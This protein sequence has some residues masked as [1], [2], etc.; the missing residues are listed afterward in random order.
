MGDG[1]LLQALQIQHY[2]SPFATPDDARKEAGVLRYS[3]GDDRDGYSV[4]GMV[5]HQLWTNTTD[6][7]IRA[8]TEGRVPNRFGSLDPS[9]GGRAWRS[10]LS[11]GDQDGRRLSRGTAGD[12]RI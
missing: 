5:Y 2:G 3:A 1:H 7:P 12:R 4:T 10:S 9:D 11:F 6:I 8:I